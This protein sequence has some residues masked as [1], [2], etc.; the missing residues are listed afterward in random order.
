MRAA[1]ADREM[2]RRWVQKAEHDLLTASHTLKLTD[3]CPYDTICFHAQQCVE[4][5][6]KGL[7][8]Q[9]E[10][11]FPRTHDLRLLIQKLP[12]AVA[13]SL[14]R[15]DALALNRYA[16]EARYPE[17]WDPISRLETEKAISTAKK[18]RRL[19]RQHLPRAILRKP[20]TS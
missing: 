1:E 3:D 15:D 14:P 18:V 2:L 8:F 7:L 19:I 6:L 5:Y 11:D 17:D 20:K 10:I 12:R 9:L 4:K 16:I 13:K